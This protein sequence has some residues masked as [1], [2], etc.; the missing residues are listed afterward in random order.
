[1]ASNDQAVLVVGQVV[2]G[3][4]ARC[5]CIAPFIA[6]RWVCKV[7]HLVPGAA[8]TSIEPLVRSTTDVEPLPAGAQHGARKRDESGRVIQETR[9]WH[10]LSGLKGLR[11]G[12]LSRG[13]TLLVIGECKLYVLMFNPA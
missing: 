2:Q 13:D 11:P 12:M 3:G 8:Q 5:P 1:M 6:V 9:T 7:A 10:R 4:F